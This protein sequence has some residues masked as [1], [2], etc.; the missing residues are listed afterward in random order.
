M[1]GISHSVDVT[2]SSLYEA[3]G[4]A[5]HAFRKSGIAEP[6]GAMKLTVRVCQ[7]ETE[8]QVTMQ[9]LERWLDSGVKS[10]KEESLRSRLRTLLGLGDRS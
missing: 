1:D 10:P 5:V 3:A 2:A 7:P 8:H 6:G 4:L 9:S